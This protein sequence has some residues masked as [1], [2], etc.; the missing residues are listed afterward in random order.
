MPNVERFCTYTQSLDYVRRHCSF[1]SP[2]EK[3]A[4]L[5]GNLQSMLA[6]DIRKRSVA[7]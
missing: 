3:D 6:I 2:S 5:G 7:A 1:L 4:V